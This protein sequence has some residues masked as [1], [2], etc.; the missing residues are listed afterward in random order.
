MSAIL[1]LA[2]SIC[3]GQLSQLCRFRSLFSALSIYH[4]VDQSSSILALVDQPLAGIP[5]S[6]YTTNPAIPRLAVVFRRC[7][8]WPCC[9]VCSTWLEL[10]PGTSGSHT[11]GFICMTLGRHMS[12]SANC[13]HLHQHQ[14][15]SAVLVYGSP[16]A[17]LAQPRA[18]IGGHFLSALVG[19]CVTKL[20]GFLPSEARFESLRWLAASLSTSIAIVVMQITKTTHPP[21]GATALLP[22]IDAA[23]RGL[24]WYL[25]P[26]VLL[27]SVLMLA[28]GLVINNLQRRYPTYWI[29]PAVPKT[30]PKADSNDITAV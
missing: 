10:L 24:S 25:L 30:V 13:L 6:S 5:C 4:H 8:L 26:V 3:F 7:F 15:A 21:A 12:F 1:Y 28:T 18:L 9:S 20:F 22:A 23:V 16:E 2:Q 29:T 27:S 19:I 17:P 11:G 14:G